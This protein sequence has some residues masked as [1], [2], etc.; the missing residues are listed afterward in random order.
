M[1]KTIEK[2]TKLSSDGRQLTTRI[3]KEI[4]EEA[5][6]KK[7]EKLVWKAKGEKLEVRKE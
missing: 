5:E 3:P 1:V 2:T 7:G 6:L 4:A